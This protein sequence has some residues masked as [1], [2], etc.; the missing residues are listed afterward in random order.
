V[1]DYRAMFR[2]AFPGFFV[3]HQQADFLEYFQ[4]RLVYVLDIVCVQVREVVH[5]AGVL[6]LSGLRKL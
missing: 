3:A 2:E 5:C 6:R 1:I 4:R